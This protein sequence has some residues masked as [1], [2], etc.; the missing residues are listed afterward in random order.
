MTKSDTFHLND[1][2]IALSLLTRLPAPEPDWQDDTPA[3]RAAWAYPIAG[4]SVAILAGV[5]AHALLWAGLNASLV[6][7]FAL[8]ILTIST[9]AMHEDGLADCADGFWGGWDKDRRL[10]IMKDSSIGTYGVMALVLSVGLR[11]MA[12]ALLFDGGWVLAPL[13]ASAVASRSA[14]TWVMHLLP[15]ARDDGLAVQ[16]GRP[17]AQAVYASTALSAVLCLVLTGFG[18]LAI[19]LAAGLAMGLVSGIARRKIDG[20]TGDVLGATQQVSDVFVICVLTLML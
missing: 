7:G 18:T 9:G 5:A 2:W 3:A 13:I 12:L 4:V 17:G 20:Q 19:V 15:H 14:M 6:A 10:R 16:T 11:W 8:A 1:I